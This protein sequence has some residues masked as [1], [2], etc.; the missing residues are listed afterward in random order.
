MKNHFHLCVRIKTEEE[1]VH[2]QTSQVSMN[3]DV[4][5][6]KFTPSRNFSNFFNAYAKAVNKGYGRTGSLFEE[7]FGRIAV[8]T[9]SYILTLIYYIHSNPQKHG[10][11]NDFQNWKWSSYSALTSVVPTQSNRTEALDI[12][13]GLKGFVEF[14]RNPLDESKLGSIIDPEFDSETSIF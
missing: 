14:H 12:F 13:G 2:Q 10:F 11:V 9:S 7:R 3:R 8:L 6:S 4:F 5:P 1:L